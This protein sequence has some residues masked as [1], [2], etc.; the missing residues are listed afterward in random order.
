MTNERLAL[1]N[2]VACPLPTTSQPMIEPRRLLP[3][4][5]AA[6]NVTRSTLE[7]LEGRR[8]LASANSQ[9][10]NFNDEALWDNHFPAAVAEAKAL[11][12]TSVRL[13]YG[14]DYYSARPQ[15]WDA[16]PAYGTE[17]SPEVDPNA[18]VMK[19]A[20]QLHAL[21]FSVLLVLQQS[22]GIPPKSPE[23]VRQMIDWLMNAK[24][25]PTG[26]QTLA[27]AVD[28]WEIGNEPDSAAYWQPSAQ[29]KTAGL[30]DYVDDF[31]IPAAQELHADAAHPARVVS[32]GVSY[33]P[34]DVK[35][36]LDELAALHALNDI[37]Y[38]GMHPYGTFNPAKPDAPGGMKANTELAV[39]YADAVDK[40]LMATEW[41]VRG[42]GASSA[43]QA[44]WAH[45]MD[46]AY[47]TV[48]RPNYTVAYYF[49]LINNWP[50]RGGAVSARPGGLLT[51][52]TPLAVTPDSSIGT[53][54]D[55]YNSP[56]VHSSP[57]YDVFASWQA[58][59]SAPG[60]GT[61]SGR[62]WSD[63]NAD[64]IFD[65]SDSAVADRIVYLDLNSDGAMDAGDLVTVT[66][67]HGRYAFTDLPPGDYRVSHPF[68]AG[69]HLIDTA[70]NYVA[71]ELMAGETETGIDLGG[72]KK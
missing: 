51:H 41:N 68:A 37:D 34:H 18:L 47:R 13:W 30:K 28:Y 24:E 43:E 4:S 53:L 69:Y 22:Q 71:V 62:L 65:G 36:I 23:L 66:N 15:A 25:S 60:D 26:T 64:G 59:G 11:G 50:A 56:L 32:A 2:A 12:I 67:S 20:F 39:R 16:V 31:L 38:V 52:D 8:M 33:D 42:Y 35:S 6:I 10:I 29:N 3:R 61:I 58:I 19:R 21:G 1:T 48:I 45:A 63:A 55:Y 17:K 40:P 9:A 7:P 57:F 5:N 54:A 27:S 14:F 46:L 70:Q 72:S 49:A 44:A